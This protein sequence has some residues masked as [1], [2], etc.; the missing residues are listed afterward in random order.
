MG[1]R[2]L[3]WARPGPALGLLLLALAGAVPAAGTG[4]PSLQDGPR[5]GGRA[6]PGG[7]VTAGAASGKRPPR[8]A[9][10]C[11]ASPAPSEAGRPLLR[12]R[13]PGPGGA[14]RPSGYGLGAAG[15][16]GAAAR[17]SGELGAER[18]NAELLCGCRSQNRSSVGWR[19][20]PG[21]PRPSPATAVPYSSSH[22]WVSHGPEYL[23]RRDPAASGQPVPELCH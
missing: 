1:P 2:R 8:R 11:C 9:A 13:V 18:L 20:V 16:N 7:E 17:A 6:V 23:Q 22:S 21:S 4:L 14:G 3:P 10:R 12:L 19:G 15:G 5:G